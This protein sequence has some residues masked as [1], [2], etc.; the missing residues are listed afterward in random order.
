MDDIPKPDP[1][2]IPPENP[3]LGMPVPPQIRFCGQCGA[4]LPT[5][6][7]ACQFCLQQSMQ[8]LDGRTYHAEMSEIKAALTLYFS[9]LA[10]SVI[11]IV[12]VMAVGPLGVHGEIVV[13]SAMSLVVLVWSILRWDTVRCVLRSTSRGGWYLLAL[14][15][16]VGTFFLATF[17]AQLVI[18]HFQ[19]EQVFYLDPYEEEGW[20]FAWPV[21]LVCVQPAAFE[22][23][24]FRGV[25]QGSVQSVVGPWQAVLVSAAMFAILHLSI[26]SLPHLLT[27][28]IVLG[29]MRMHSGSIFPGMIVHFIHNLLVLLDE[30]AGG[31]LA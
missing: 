8:K 14:V 28:G 6:S 24:A 22:E 23:L 25:I 21:L 3:D 4:P 9:L 2:V 16:P 29:W 7:A 19:A 12:V 27:L 1:L 17:S 13:S 11:T 15:I 18:E 5:E 20:S 26:I 31:F 10:I 30:S